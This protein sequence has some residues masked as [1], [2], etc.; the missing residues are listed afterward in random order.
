MSAKANHK[1]LLNEFKNADSQQFNELVEDFNNVYKL[2]SYIEQLEN[3]RDKAIEQCNDWIKF[4]KK[5]NSDE[6]LILRLEEISRTLKG[7]SD[8]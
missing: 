3:N 8:E 7:D 6:R 1:E 4:Y 2:L 5:L